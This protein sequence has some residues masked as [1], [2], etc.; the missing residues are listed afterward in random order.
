MKNK[1]PHL[2][3]VTG[4]FRGKYHTI[5]NGVTLYFDMYSGKIFKEDKT[6]FT[7]DSLVLSRELISAVLEVEGKNI[8][9]FELELL[10]NTGVGL[11]SGQGSSPLMMVRVS[12]DGGR[13]FS[14]IRNLTLSALGVHNFRHRL[15]RFGA[16]RRYVTHLKVTDPVDIMIHTAVAELLVGLR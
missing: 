10:G 11:L 15:N 1:A 8:A 9:S 2:T 14:Q 13:S 4:P 6:V 5:F 16:G 3:P 7:D 12:K